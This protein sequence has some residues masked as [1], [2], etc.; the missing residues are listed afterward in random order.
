MVAKEESAPGLHGIPSGLH[1]CAGGTFTKRNRHMIEGGPTR[2]LFAASRTYCVC[3]QIHDVDDNGRMIA[4]RI[5]SVIVTARF[6]IRLRDVSRPGNWTDNIFEV[7]TTTSAQVACAPR[8]SG[9]LLTDF[10]AVHLGV[11]LSWNFHV[12][13]KAELLGFICRFLRKNSRSS[14][15]V[16]CAGTTG[17]QFFMARCV[18]AR[19][20]CE[21]LPVFDGFPSSVGSRTRSSQGNPAGL[22]FLE[23]VPCAYADDFVVS[24]SSFP[25]V[26]AAL[27]PALSGGPN[28]WAQL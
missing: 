8:E 26:G 4:G 9:I 11:N 28:R 21:R 15:H 5:L 16:E 6:S 13:E 14:T 1:R 25:T 23:L 2:A 22:D 10:A 20:S 19:L 7:E 12:L 24:A 18:E 27:T 17:G 3:S